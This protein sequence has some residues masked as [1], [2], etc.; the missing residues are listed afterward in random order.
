MGNNITKLTRLEISTEIQNTINYRMNNLSRVFIL[1]IGDTCSNFVQQIM[2]ME[3]AENEAIMKII[4]DTLQLQKMA[5]EIQTQLVNKC[6][7]DMMVKESLE[8]FYLLKEIKIRGGGPEAMVDSIRIAIRELGITLSGSNTREQNETLIKNK[9]QTSMKSNFSTLSVE[10]K[11]IIKNQTD[12]MVQNILDNKC[13]FDTSGSN[14]MNLGNINN[15]DIPVSRNTFIE[16]VINSMSVNSMIAKIV[17]M[18]AMKEMPIIKTDI[19]KS[20]TPIY[21]VFDKDG[22][23]DLTCTKYPKYPGCPEKFTN[24]TDD[25]NCDTIISI[26]CML[27]I[28]FLLFSIIKKKI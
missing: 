27:A 18:P 24:V 9:I 19:K 17:G 28:F 8:I 5:L 16:C 23:K 13:G 26:L 1:T 4:N 25:D 22:M 6:T 3:S 2:M 14:S 21:E 11:N 7:S 15:K 20:Y 10:I 12:N